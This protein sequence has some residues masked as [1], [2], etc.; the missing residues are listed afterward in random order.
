MNKIEKTPFEHNRWSP[1]NITSETKKFLLAISNPE[2][3][4]LSLYLD[5]IEGTV[6]EGLE[7]TLVRNGPAL[8]QRAEQTVRHLFDGDGMVTKWHFEQGRIHFSNKYVYTDAYKKESKVGKF[9]FPSL[10]GHTPGGPRA[11]PIK[12]MPKNTANTNAILWENE[13]YALWEGGAPHILNLDDLETLRVP[14]FR[15]G[16]RFSAH[17]KIE[18]EKTGQKMLINFGINP[19][20]FGTWIS[21]F[22]ARGSAPFKRTRHIRVPGFVYVHDMVVT[23]N[24]YIFYVYNLN[25]ALSKILL[26]RRTVLQSLSA[27]HSRQPYALFLDRKGA[28][29]QRIPLPGY[30]VM[31]HANAFA[32][33][34]RII[35]DSFIQ[36]GFSMELMNFETGDYDMD[37][38]ASA[39]LHRLS[40]DL[41]AKSFEIIY[42]EKQSS[43]FPAL[44]PNWLGRSYR[45]LYA[46]TSEIT[47]H[48]YSMAGLF[49]LDWHTGLR[50][51]WYPGSFRFVTEPVFAPDMSVGALGSEISGW[52][53]SALIDVNIKRVSLLIFD[54]KRISQGPVAQIH[55]P[56]FVLPGLLHGSFT[57]HEP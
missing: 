54:P 19:T 26:W 46:T 28:D 15:G 27:D 6:P 14:N 40:F 20:L 23:E 7:G 45:Y 50:D 44:H 42:T 37:K 24:Y 51:V 41:S 9:L 21:V 57:L 33:G 52:L 55:L 39:C 4:E 31:H 3:S 36:D 22:E 2:Q 49:S 30:F 1:E 47:D 13:I 29:D 8:F 10:S 53:L 56:K 43:D 16:A 5:D 25:V 35:V 18:I 48:Y 34:N 17:P 38:M 11:W 32:D 12:I